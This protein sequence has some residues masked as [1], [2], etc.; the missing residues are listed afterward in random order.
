MTFRCLG[1]H[2]GGQRN[3][4]PHFFIRRAK[5]LQQFNNHAHL[6]LPDAFHS[7]LFHSHS[8]TSF[9]NRAQWSSLCLVCH[10][11]ETRARECQG[12][13]CRLA[14]N[15]CAQFYYSCAL[16]ACI[17]PYFLDLHPD[18]NDFQNLMDSSSYNDTSSSLAELNIQN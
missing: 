14:N 8:Y 6:L 18:P 2:Q 16:Q 12:P 5:N 10:R 3:N 11:S 1:V 15:N 4:V 13:F 17:L 7:A 9:A